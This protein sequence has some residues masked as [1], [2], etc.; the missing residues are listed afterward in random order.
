VQI[1][2][3]VRKACIVAGYVPALGV[4]FSSSPCY[5]SVHQGP[6]GKEVGRKEK[7]KRKNLSSLNLSHL[8][9]QKNPTTTIIIISNLSYLSH[10][11]KQ[12]MAQK[13][14]H[15]RNSAI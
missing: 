4:W 7:K 9:S 12:N 2:T 14:Q 5:L 8:S 13:P 6:D 3:C 1:S 15:I 11:K 10:Q